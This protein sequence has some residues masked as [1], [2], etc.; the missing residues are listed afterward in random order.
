MTTVDALKGL[1][2]FLEKEVASSIKLQKEDSVPPEYVNPYV[3]IIALPHKNFVPTNFQVPNICIGLNDKRSRT[4]SIAQRQFNFPRS[5]NSY[6]LHITKSR[7]GNDIAGMNVIA[8]GI[9]TAARQLNRF[10]HCR[11]TQANHQQCRQEHSIN[12][13]QLHGCSFFL[14]FLNPYFIIIRM[15]CQETSW[16]LAKCNIFGIKKARPCGRAFKQLI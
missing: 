11:R 9:R 14:S 16:L 1:K 13:I 8:A 4:V 10:R 6:N 2:N 12:P 15:L 7:A 5:G 3:A